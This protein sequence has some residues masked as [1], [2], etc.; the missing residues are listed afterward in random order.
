MEMKRFKRLFVFF[1][2][3]L[4]LVATFISTT[5][6]EDPKTPTLLRGLDAVHVQVKDFDPELKKE[7]RKV[8]LIEDQ[9]QIAVERR[10]EKAGMTVQSEEQFR[11]STAK[12]VL[13]IKL[14]LMPEAVQKVR[15]TFTEEGEQVPKT[16]DT[17]KYV[18]R[19]D[20]VLRQSVSLIRDPSAQGMAVTWSA[21]SVGYRRLIR[22]QADLMDQVD[23]FIDA[24]KAAN[25]R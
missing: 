21:G 19:T 5:T 2:G 8:G 3:V 23:K 18:Y 13:L 20:V 12:A 22:V 6:G 25:T 9:V 11:K 4:L 14:E 15:Y 16:D 17:L 7:L 1:F 10:L 24:H